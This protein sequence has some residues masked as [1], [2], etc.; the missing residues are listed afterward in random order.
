[1]WLHFDEILYEQLFGGFIFC[2]GQALYKQLHLLVA[3]KERKLPIKTLFDICS[4]TS[5]QQKLWCHSEWT[6]PVKK[7][8]LK[9]FIF[10]F[11]THQNTS[12]QAMQRRL[13]NTS[14]FDLKTTA[15][16]SFYVEYDLSACK[17]IITSSGCCCYP[18][19][20][21]ECELNRAPI[22]QLM[23]FLEPGER[24]CSLQ[25]AAPSIP[26]LSN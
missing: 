16:S 12:S 3:E 26:L 19:F 23:S 25:V 18:H 22:N 2:R 7:W 10:V 15:C 9:Y 14:N 17:C 8:V 6:L 21:P 5:Q 1:M 13:K 11:R 4:G 24:G 20:F